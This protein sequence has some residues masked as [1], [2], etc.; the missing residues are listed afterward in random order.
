MKYSIAPFYS[1]RKKI[2]VESGE[3]KREIRIHC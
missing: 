1:D 2:I 3:G